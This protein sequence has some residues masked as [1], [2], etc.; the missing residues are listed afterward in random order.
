MKG[1]LY[2][3][4]TP[5]GNLEDI[6]VRAM[7]ILKEVDG[8]AAEDT[9][10]TKRLTNHLDVHKPMISLH[11]HNE[12][13][14]IE[15]LRDKLQQ[16]E[17]W[18]LVSDAG[19]PGICDPGAPVIAALRDQ[20]FSIVP[21]PGPS[22]L[23]TAMSASGLT[24][25]R[26]LFEG[27]L[28]PR[29]TDRKKRLDALNETSCALA[30]YEAPHRIAKTLLELSE[31]W[32]ERKITVCRELTKLHEEIVTLPLKEAAEKFSEPRGEFV[33]IVHPAPPKEEKTA[34]P[35]DILALMEEK[36]SAGLSRKQAAAEIAALF[37]RRT[38]EIYTLSLKN[39]P[40]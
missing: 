38:N 24:D 1:T 7:R 37:N 31:R 18:A 23:I 27:F 13:E 11:M 20:G 17:N 12:R 25:S 15:F 26:F 32:P 14:K 30:F 5:I 29:G 19:T 9:R 3:V 22:A 8:I 16:G 33:L 6:T 2:I 40:F 34:S 39:N 21:I 35:E 10:H 28:P 4:A 36:M